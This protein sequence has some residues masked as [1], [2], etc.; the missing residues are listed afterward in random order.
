MN[1]TTCIDCSRGTERGF[2]LVASAV[3]WSESPRPLIL[4][5]DLFPQAHSPRGVYAARPVNIPAERCKHCHV[6]AVRS[7]ASCVH[8]LKAGWVFPYASLRW[9]SG[10]TEFVPTFLYPFTNRG[11]GGALAVTLFRPGF[12]ISI[13]NARL[14][15]RV[16]S[17][18]HRI[19]IRYAQHGEPIAPA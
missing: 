8:E 12:R 3:F 7:P 15:S 4:L 13:R 19:W 18:C 9:V 17:R 5:N 6:V 14:P 16:C 10:D 1:E 2:F 11:K